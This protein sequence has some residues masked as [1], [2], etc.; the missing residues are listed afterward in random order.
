[1]RWFRRPEP[2]FVR[3]IALSHDTFFSRLAWKLERFK[4]V[5]V[6]Y[7]AQLAADARLS[8]RLLRLWEDSLPRTEWPFATEWGGTE[9]AAPIPFDSFPFHP[10][11]AE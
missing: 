3:I 10:F 6:A 1:M 9:I 7:R 8:E 5:K 11:E 4:L 2:H